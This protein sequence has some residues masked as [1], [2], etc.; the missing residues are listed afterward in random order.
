MSS[1]DYKRSSS[2]SHH[3]HLLIAHPSQPFDAFQMSFNNFKLEEFTSMTSGKEASGFIPWIPLSTASPGANLSTTEQ[4]TV[5]HSQKSNFAFVVQ[6]GPAL[7]T[8]EMKRFVKKHV[9]LD[10]GYA[11]RKQMKKL[12]PGA[13]LN[14][15][16]TFDVFIPSVPR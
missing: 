11:R 3:R 16:N 4:F 10:I 2:S 7:Q 14:Q 15:Q 8:A 1:S 9:M 5:N 13:A 12:R 6:D